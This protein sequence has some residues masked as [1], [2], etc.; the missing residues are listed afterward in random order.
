MLSA[1]INVPREMTGFIATNACRKEMA[2]HM[3]FSPSPVVLSAGSEIAFTPPSKEWLLQAAVVL[4]V[5][6]STQMA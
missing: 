5:R 6:D 2:M 4:P 3:W 1:D